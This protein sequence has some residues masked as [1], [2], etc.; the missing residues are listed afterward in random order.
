MNTERR[1]ILEMLA[2]KKITA[3]EAEKLIS[4][5]ENQDVQSS[6][7]GS[8]KKAKPKY[9]RVVVEDDKQDG[10]SKV[11]IRVPM[12]LLHAGVKLASLIPQHAREHVNTALKDHGVA[13]DLSQI[14][15]ENLEELVDNLSELT[16][17]VEDQSSDGPSR[18]KIFCE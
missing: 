12:Q 14:K 17:D 7:F 16:V 18:V 3:D 4:A 8:S 13:L 9:L 6:T 15:P 10:P 11:N 5:L 2:D 1:Q